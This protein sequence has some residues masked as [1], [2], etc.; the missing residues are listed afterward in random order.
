MR[1]LASTDYALRVL[2]LLGQAPPDIH[3]S[4]E[5]LAERLGGL[6]RHH[7]HKIVQ[8]L[9][10][11]GVTRTVRGAGGGV[12]LAKPPETIGL[13]ALI[14]HLE[15]GQ[16]MVACFKSDDS[17]CTLLP[18]CR[19]RGIVARA[20]QDFY[21]RLDEYTLADCLLTGA[22]FQNEDAAPRVSP[23]NA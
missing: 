15:A 22:G 21:A 6:S 23:T 3:L 11:Q 12:M 10:A 7:L 8:D 19:L 18:G 5:T 16:A 4:V 17:G 1:L 2:M 14:R 20:E 9:T 13:G